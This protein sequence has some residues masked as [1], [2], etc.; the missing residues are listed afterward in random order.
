MN[1]LLTV[2]NA[3]DWKTNIAE[4]L[5]AG[6]TLAEVDAAAHRIAVWSRQL[7][8]A[9]RENPALSFVREMQHSIQHAGALIGLCLFKPSAACSRTLVESC[10]YYTYFRNHSEELA[11]LIRDSRYYVS[12]SEIIEYH[13]IHTNHFKSHQQSF[14]L[15]SSL[16]DWY[17]SVSA[18]VH[19]QIP[20][21]WNTHDDLS[22]TSFADDVQKLALKTLVDG[23]NI[24][25]DLLFCTISGTLWRKFAPEA[26]A[27]LIKG[28]PANKR[29][30]LGLDRN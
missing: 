19:G 5:G 13:K 10:I 12:K 23:T 4:S 8:E 16:D 25:N 27:F 20:G 15:V 11:T 29:E 26:K 3:I 18:I 30:A 24:V 28:M 22:K 7:E 9:D 17:S 2:L 21:S 6:T 14:N 1:N